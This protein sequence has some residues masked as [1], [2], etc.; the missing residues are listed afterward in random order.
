MHAC[1]S[2]CASSNNMTIIPP[3]EAPALDPGLAAVP[4]TLKPNIRTLI[5][6]HG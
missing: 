4:V 2:T 3:C 1:D 5:N 6:V